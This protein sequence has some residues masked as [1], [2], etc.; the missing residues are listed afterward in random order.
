MQLQSGLIRCHGILVERQNNNNFRADNSA[1][2]EILNWGL[3]YNLQEFTRK[4]LAVNTRGWEVRKNV[5]LSE[6][7]EDKT[8]NRIPDDITRPAANLPALKI[9]KMTSN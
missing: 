8:S 4:V 9:K 1:P 7:R 3:S 5:I 6:V 2:A